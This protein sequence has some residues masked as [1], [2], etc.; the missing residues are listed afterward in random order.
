VSEI[1]NACPKFGISSSLKIGV[2]KLLTGNVSRRLRKLTEHL[3]A[4][5]F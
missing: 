2:Q 5:I 1:W 4:N 3:T